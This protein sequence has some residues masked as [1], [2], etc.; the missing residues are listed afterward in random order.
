MGIDELDS[1]SGDIFR[2][3][4]VTNIEISPVAVSQVY[5]PAGTTEDMETIEV[6]D[7][8]VSQLYQIVNKYD[9]DFTPAKPV[10]PRLLNPNG[11]PKVFYH[12]TPNGTFI[13]YNR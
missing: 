3:Y 6:S 12:G 8:T 4:N 9:S 2:A 1:K 10:D 13:P 5:R 11:T 7:T